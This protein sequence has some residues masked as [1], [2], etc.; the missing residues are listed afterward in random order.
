MTAVVAFAG[1]DAASGTNAPNKAALFTRLGSF[2]ERVKKG[3]SGEKLLAALGQRWPVSTRPWCWSFHL[4]RFAAWGTLGVS[5]DGAGSPGRGYQALEASSQEVVAEGMKQPELVGLFSGYRA[6]APQLYADIDRTKAQML[7]VPMENVFST[8]QT[9]SDPSCERFNLYGRTFRVV[10]QADAR[11]REDPE[12]VAS[13][14]RAAPQE[15]PFPGNHPFLQP[16]TGPS[17]VERYNLYPAAAV[18]G[19]TAPDLARPGAR[20]DG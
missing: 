17:R 1:F 5:H 8:L 18:D 20:G 13:F 4:R 6:N 19:D 3:Q 11:F 16:R 2:E 12:D 14:A 7:H 10:A 9:N 15:L